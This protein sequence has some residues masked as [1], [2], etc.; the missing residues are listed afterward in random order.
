MKNRRARHP[1]LLS[2]RLL[3]CLLLVCAPAAAF[4]Q[5][6]APDPVPAVSPQPSDQGGL[7]EVIVTANKRE[8]SMEKVGLS[9]QAISGAQLEDRRITSLED[10]AAAVPGLSFAESANETPIFTL[11]GVGFNE[12]SLGVYPAVSVYVDQIPLPFPVMASHSAFDLQQ[13]EVLKG[14]QGTL[15]GQNSTGGAINYIAAKPTEDFKAGAD[16]SYGRFNETDQDAF[17]SGPITDTLQARVAVTSHHMDD[18]QYSVTRP[19]DTNGHQSYVAGRGLLDWQPSERIRFSLNVNG[20]ND[21][22]QPQ[23]WQMIGIRTQYPQYEPTAFPNPVFSPNNPRAADWTVSFLDPALGVT[24]PV[25]GAS[26]PGTAQLNDIAPF[27]DRSFEQGGL[28]TDVDLTQDITLTSLTSYDNY[29]QRESID[30][31]GTPYVIENFPDLNG[32]IHSFNE[33]LR[34]ANTAK[35]RFRWILGTNFEHSITSEYQDNR[36]QHTAYNPGNLYIN[37][38]VVENEQRIRNYAFFN[39]SEFS[40]TDLLTVKAGVRYTDSSNKADICG[41][42]IPGGNVNTL[43]NVLGTVLGKVPFTPI[44]PSACYTLNQNYVPGQPFIDTLNEN[45]VSWKGGLDY[46]IAPNTLLYTN[47]S[48]GYKAGNFP[49]LAAALYTAL[50]PVTQESVTAYEG[51]IKTQ[52]FDRMLTLDSAVFYY[53]YKNKQVLGKLSDPIFGALEAL[54]NVP[55]SRIYG[56]EADVTAQPL[57]GLTLSANVTYLNSKIQEY[58]GVNY[59]GQPNFN[60]AGDPLPFTPEWSTSLNVDYRLS[61]TKGTPFI[62]FSV[63][64]RSEQDAAISAQRLDYFSEPN[65][66][67]RPGVGCVYCVAGYATTDARLGYES[68]D[69]RWKVTLWGKNIFNKYYWTNV[70]AAYD[71]SARIAGMPATYGVTIGYKLD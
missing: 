16:L 1:S 45:N 71:D 6:T 56:A 48:K 21:T 22:S 11:R 54:V 46:Q 63:S 34:A 31:D 40:L 17:L 66:Y 52:L 59:L 15:F 13:I 5:A 10:V 65:V 60:S 70:I 4:A 7:A 58:T 53:D 9:I 14:P 69:A 25:T 64:E 37:A 41:S 44:G 3:G 30:N 43:F 19:N 67:L 35:D 57:H 68:Q 32:Y 50:K 8:E 61:T 29:T 23:A 24:N 51:G 26:V 38:S 28:R 47:V 20:W 49:S 42:T 18:W 27:G 39:N 55:K 62:G 36:Y 12:S 33:E 2:W